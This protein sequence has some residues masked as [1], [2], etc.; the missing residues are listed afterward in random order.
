M[1]SERQDE[2]Y[3]GGEAATQALSSTVV[4]NAFVE[5]VY[6]K[7]SGVYDL[8]FGPTL[9]PGRLQAFERMIIA[10]GSSILEVGVGTGINLRH[11]PR[12]AVVG[13]DL[14]RHVREGPRAHRQE[15]LRNA[16]PRDGRRALSFEDNS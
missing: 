4:E 12:S 10:E 2:K 6:E 1:F 13:I 14:G 5:R 9:H 16:R 7:I 8:T 11:Y 3:M 15:R